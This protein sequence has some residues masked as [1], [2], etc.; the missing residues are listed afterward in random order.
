LYEAERAREHR[1]IV[2]APELEREEIRDIYRNKGFSGRLLDE[3]VETITSNPEVWVAVMMAEE[4]ELAPIARHAAERAALVVG[5]S[6]LI[7]SLIPLAPYG[8]LSIGA[9][10]W[11]ALA[12]AGAVL[13]LVGAYQAMTTV[14][15]WLRSG[16]TMATIGL[17][18]ALVGYGV[19]LLFKLP[20][21][22]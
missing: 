20:T 17:L 22:P 2:V 8:F 4:L 21:Q 6:A 19:G 13:F 11:T 16:M 12:M 10:T 1:H 14:G 5:V 15:H 18:S 9:A 7:G 3:I